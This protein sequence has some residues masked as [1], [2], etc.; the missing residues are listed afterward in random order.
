MI[1]ELNKHIWKRKKFKPLQINCKVPK[2]ISSIKLKIVLYIYRTGQ[3]NFYFIS[4]LLSN[5]YYNHLQEKFCFIKGFIF[6]FHYKE[7]SLRIYCMPKITSNMLVAK[8]QLGREKM[9]KSSQMKT[10]HWVR[11]IHNPEQFRLS[12]R[13]QRA[14]GSPA[15]PAYMPSS[16]LQRHKAR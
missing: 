13:C 9:R 5:Q 12:P 15:P 10:T 11:G 8:V 6:R 14:P 3:Y 1:S 4:I 7:N 2:G 16:A